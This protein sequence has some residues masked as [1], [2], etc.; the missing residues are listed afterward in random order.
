VLNYDRATNPEQFNSYYTFSTAYL[1]HGFLN[2]SLLQL[3]PELARENAKQQLYREH[4]FPGHHY[5]VPV[6]NALKPITD[7]NWPVYWC[8]I[9][10]MD[11]QELIHCVNAY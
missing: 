8:G 6:A 1:M 3:Y 11:Q 4:Y 5:S 9:G 10:K 7:L 2:D